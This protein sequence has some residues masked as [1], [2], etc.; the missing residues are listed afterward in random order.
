MSSPLRI[1][2]RSLGKAQGAIFFR[3][4]LDPRFHGND[5]LFGLV[6]LLNKLM[7]TLACR[8]PFNVGIEAPASRPAH[9]G[10]DSPCIKVFAFLPACFSYHS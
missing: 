7:V 6:S 8:L 1:P 3:L 10:I 9:H 5:V 2:D 4:G